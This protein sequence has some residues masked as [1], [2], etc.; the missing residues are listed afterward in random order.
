MCGN[1]LLQLLFNA[2]RFWNKK[3]GTDNHGHGRTSNC[4]SSLEN[5]RI[6]S[7][8]N[9][10]MMTASSVLRAVVSKTLGTGEAVRITVP[11][12]ILLLGGEMDLTIPQW[13]TIRSGS[14]IV[15]CNYRFCDEYLCTCFF[16]WC[17]V[18]HRNSFE[19][20]WGCPW[21]FVWKT[22]RKW[23]KQKQHVSEGS[24]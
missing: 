10:R 5:L 12:L 4:R 19:L 6:A 21:L 17:V 8:Q 3:L 11:P 13:S 15:H 22:T 9:F 24:K 18:F 16:H 1:W 20:N 2:T 7:A 23:R 14:Q